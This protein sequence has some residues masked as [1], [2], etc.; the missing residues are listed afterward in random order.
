MLQPKDNNGHT[1]PE[2]LAFDLTSTLREIT[3]TSCYL[4]DNDNIELSHKR[5]SN[6]D[7]KFLRA[8]NSMYICKDM[9]SRSLKVD[10]PLFD[11]AKFV[12][13]DMFN[14]TVLFESAKLVLFSSNKH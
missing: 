10:R 2:Q 14:N 1:V 7:L 5:M 12:F 13:K 4:F 3:L 8:D 6:S 11:R 9:S